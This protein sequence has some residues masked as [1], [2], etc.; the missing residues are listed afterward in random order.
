MVH[1]SVIRG[2]APRG[3]AYIG[4]GLDSV[5]RRSVRAGTILSEQQQGATRTRSR[6]DAVALIE[7]DRTLSRLRVRKNSCGKEKFY[8]YLKVYAY[9]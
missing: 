2:S 1:A 7:V 4:F 8:S 5:T 6:A 9:T 3:C